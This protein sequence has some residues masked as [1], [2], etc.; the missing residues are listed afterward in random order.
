MTPSDPTSPSGAPFD[1][2]DR[3]RVARSAAVFSAAT[4]VSLK[5][6]RSSPITSGDGSS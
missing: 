3:R 5:F 6:F 4:A 2:G 1:A